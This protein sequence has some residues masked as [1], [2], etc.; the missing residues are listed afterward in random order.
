[1]TFCDEFENIHIFL[2]GCSPLP[3]ISIV[4]S[5]LLAKETR[6]KSISSTNVLGSTYI[7]VVE[8]NYAQCSRNFMS[9]VSLDECS[10]CHN[11]GH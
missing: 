11:K 9:C 6:L 10:Y 4:L 8:H 2:L 1:M 5:E 3:T 7:V